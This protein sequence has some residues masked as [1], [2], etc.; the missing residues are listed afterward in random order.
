MTFLSKHPILCDHSKNEVI[1]SRK[2][3]NYRRRRYQCKNCNYRWSTLE[4]PLSRNTNNLSAHTFQQGTVL[5]AKL[6]YEHL[7]AVVN[8][9]E[10]FIEN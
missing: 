8:M 7:K 6:R 9:L 10:K 5:L 1:D 3:V 4:I 2:T